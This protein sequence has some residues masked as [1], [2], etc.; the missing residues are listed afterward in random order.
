M[1]F[2]KW[3]DS[4]VRIKVPIPTIHNGDLISFV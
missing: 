1:L 4:L 3:F 2:Y